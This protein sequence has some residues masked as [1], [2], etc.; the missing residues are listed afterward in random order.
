MEYLQNALIK[1]NSQ[2]NVSRFSTVS[3]R[4]IF[5]RI[6]ISRVLFLGKILLFFLGLRF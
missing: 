3:D 4:K 5:S 6:L 1:K 2:T